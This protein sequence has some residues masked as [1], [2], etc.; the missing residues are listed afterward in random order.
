M[1]V[2]WELIEYRE[3]LTGLVATETCQRMIWNIECQTTHQ[4]SEAAP[5]GTLP[6]QDVHISV[7]V[8]PIWQQAAKLS[9]VK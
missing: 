4:T 9:V 3:S 1:Y 5:A 6:S 7:H 2:E 8:D